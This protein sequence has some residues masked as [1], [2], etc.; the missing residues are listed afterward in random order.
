MFSSPIL[1]PTPVSPSNVTKSALVKINDLCIAKS[2]AQFSVLNLR[3]AFTAHHSLL[4]HFLGFQGTTLSWFSMTLVVSHSLPPQPLNF[5]GPRGLVSGLFSTYIHCLISSYLLSFKNAICS[6]TLPN[7][8]LSLGFSPQTLDLHITIYCIFTWMLHRHLKCNTSEMESSLPQLGPSQLMATLSFQSFRPKS[9]FRS[10]FLF[11]SV[12]LPWYEPSFSLGQ[13]LQQSPKQS[14]YFSPC[15]LQVYSHHSGQHDPWKIQVRLFGSSVQ[16]SVLILAPF[17]A[18][19]K[20]Q[21][22]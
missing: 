4:T 3:G 20:L 11:P 9:Q 13:T 16:V 5:E 1:I 15:P 8:Y 19:S 21:W 6:Q 22:P 10:Q 14:S 12:L 18:N 17:Y 2:N 7:L